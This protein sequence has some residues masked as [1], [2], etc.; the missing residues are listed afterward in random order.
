MSKSLRIFIADDHPL[1]LKGL[2]DYLKE[3]D[4]NIVGSAGDGQ[5]ACQMILNCE[6]DVAILDIEMPGMT[7]LEIAKACEKNGLKT[8]VVI[9]TL[10]KEPELF[11]NAKNLNIFGY[12]LKELALEEIEICLSNIGEDQPYFSPTITRLLEQSQDCTLLDDLTPSEVK[13]LRLIARDM[14]NKEIAHQLYISPRTVE[15]HRSNM[16][17]KLNLEPKTNSLLLWAKKHQ[18]FLE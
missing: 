13:I 16:I 15:K 9:I 10:H 18:I 6:P 3:R 1:I 2:S 5:L 7:G 14:T 4:Y 12:I 17:S 11:R 8:K